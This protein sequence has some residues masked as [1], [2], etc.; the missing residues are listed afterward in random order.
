[1]TEA[2]TIRRIADEAFA[3]FNSGG[4]HV[5]SFSARYPG[6][7][8]RRRLSSSSAYQQHARRAALQ[9]A[10]PQIRLY[11]SPDLAGIRVCAPNWGYVYD[12]TLHDL[13]VP[14]RSRP[15]PSRRSSRNHVRARRGTLARHGRRG[16]ARRVL[17]G[18]RTVS[19][20][21]NRSFRTGSSRRPTPSS[22]TQCT[23]HCWSGRTTR[24][25]RARANGCA[26]LRVSI[27]SFIA[28]VS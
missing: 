12:R 11:Q 21:S 13:A 3:A 20:S 25:A 22:P 6:F 27:L 1:M 8:P 28:T 17:H 4:G 26:R 2:A 18:S 19:R 7:Q 9:A 24:S 23:A 14:L 15:I 10:R 5:P 16:A